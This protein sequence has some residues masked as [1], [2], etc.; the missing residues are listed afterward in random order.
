MN[1]TEATAAQAEAAVPP[2]P[3]KRRRRRV[4]GTVMLVAV[5]ALGAVV[6]SVGF[7]RDPSVVRSVL[8][9]KPAPELQG[10]TLDGD[11]LDIGDYRGQVVLVN[12]WA[13][14]CAACRAEHPVLAATQ[15]AYASDGLQIIGI[16]M[17][18]KAADARKFLA[19]MGGATY[20]SVQDPDARIAVAWG[21]FGVPET[22]VVDRTGT[23]RE[24]AVGAVTTA[25]ITSHVAPLLD[26]P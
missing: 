20:P 9:N 26:A 5:V 22:Y 3:S 7:G 16:D 12:V 6:F 25:W 13:S 23:I 8:I 17:S 19:E 15:R 14:W 21:T 18:D 1:H 10:T 24:K 4:I 11:S 2:A